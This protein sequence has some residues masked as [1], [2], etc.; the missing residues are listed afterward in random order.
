[1]RDKDFRR[2]SHI[3]VDTPSELRN[4]IRK[5]SSM[6]L[7]GTHMTPT[8]VTYCQ[9]H[10]EFPSE[11]E[12]YL[13]LANE[14]LRSC[15]KAL[16]ASQLPRGRRGKLY[17]SES[18]AGMTNPE[19]IPHGSFVETNLSNTQKVNNL[20]QLAHCLGLKRNRDWDWRALQRPTPQ[21]IDADELLARFDAP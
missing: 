5:R 1:M 21:Y 14:M 12:A 10:H 2:A 7:L 11:K 9:K 3:F 4:R 15:K 16:R 17:F 6:R 18:G 13:W 8:I 19:R 20:D